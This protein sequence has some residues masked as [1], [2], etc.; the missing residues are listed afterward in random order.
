ML[1]RAHAPR[2]AV[3]LACKAIAI[4][5]RLIAA[6]L[7]QV[8]TPNWAGWSVTC[9]V[10]SL[11]ARRAEDKRAKMTAF[12]GALHARLGHGSSA[13]LLAAT[14]AGHDVVRSVLWPL[15]SGFA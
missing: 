8:F 9:T 7:I 11:Q 15:Y 13:A 14:E 1:L 6:L 10:A 4:F 3:A 5:N 2:H 12:M